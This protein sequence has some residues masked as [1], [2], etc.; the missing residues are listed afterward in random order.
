MLGKRFKR[1][2]AVVAGLL[3][4]YAAAGFWGVPWLVQRQ[5]PALEQA[6]RAWRA[7]AGEVRFNPF[8]LRLQARDLRLADVKGAPLLA[9]DGLEVELQWRSLW[10]RAWSFAQ[11][12]ISAPD[13]RLAIAPDGRFNL[14]QLLD[15][16]DALD[17][18]P[19]KPEQD[20]QPLPRLVVERLALTQGRLALDDRRAGYSN[21]FTPV[22][23]ELR[24]FST[25]PDSNDAYTLS[26]ETPRGGK[27][28]WKGQ[29]SLV[30]IRGNGEL[31]LEGVVLPDPAV[32]LKPYTRAGIA[33]GRLS[34]TLPYRFAYGDGRLDASLNGARLGVQ[35]LA[36][37]HQGSSEPFAT[38][39]HLD[40]GGV[41]AD[42]ARREVAV[43]EVKLS[44]GRLQARRD[45]QGVLDLATLMV[46]QGA[47]AEPATPATP[48]KA[49]ASAS[50]K[51]PEAA[52][53]APRPQ[54]QPASRAPQAFS[55]APAW[56]LAVKQVLL[57][58]LALGLVD[59]TVSPALKLSTGKLHLQLQLAAE[60]RGGQLQVMVS[61]AALALADMALASGGAT[62]VKLARLGFDGGALDLAAR[63]ASVGRVYLEGGQLQLVRDAKGRLNV[64]ELLPKAAASAPAPADAPWAAT[65]GTVALSQF[66]AE[67]HDQASGIRVHLQDMGLTLTS[68]STE[69]AKPVS[70]KAGLRVREGGQLSA[71][72]TLVPKDATLRAD[73]RVQALA[74]A[75]LQPLLAKHVRLHIAGGVV[76]AQGKLSTG[77]GTAKS[78]ALRYVGG[79]EVTRLVL[80]E[81]DGDLFAAWKRVGTDKLVASLSPNLLEMAELQVEE[82]NAKLI[83]EDDRSFNA[84]RLLVRAP[85]AAAPRQ[86]ASAA[87][88]APAAAAP[89][90]A[91]PASAAV[92]LHGAPA[93]ATAQDA[94]PDPFPVL[95]R[96]VRLRNAKLDFAD[97][98]LR[99]QFGAKIYELSGVINGLASDQRVRSQVELD[100]RV[101]EFG[102]ARVR[103]ELNP[104]APRDNTNLAVTFRNVDMVSATP[105]A[106]KFAGYKIAQ[107]KISL[108]L[109]YKVRNSQLEGDNKIVIDQLTLGERVDSPDALKLPL[110][111]AIAILKDSDGRIDLGLPVSGDMNNPQFSYGAIIWK[112]IGNVLTKIVTSPFR[113]LGALL[114]IS[115]EKLEAVDFDA[116]SASL[117]PPEREKLKQVA[118]LLAK[119]AQLKLAVP[120]AYSEAA[121]S[122]A[123]KTLALRN[124]VA[125][126]AGMKL[127]PGEAPGPLDSAD[128]AVRVALRD[129]YAKRFGAAE[130]DRQKQAAQA[131]DSNR[132]GAPATGASGAGGVGGEA[133]AAQK[134]PL[135]QRLG[136]LVQGEPQV[137]D[138]T[139]FYH[140]LQARL[141]QSQPLAGD[142]LARLGAQRAANIQ[143][144]LQEAGV[145]PARVALGAPEAV[146]GAATGKMVPVKLG[147]GAK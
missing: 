55:P 116:G 4:V 31:A 25:L 145:E 26:A 136:K 123:L 91:A 7:T 20:R 115:G 8:T 125:A 96:R 92:P 9:V 73:V 109:Q 113:A 42:L 69:L 60:Q 138:A 119:R 36:L 23:F 75:P 97:L 107:G 77:A 84:A 56:K 13:V 58:Q 50:A 43:G 30:P 46:A 47:P 68:A 86:A 38:L 2:V 64:L 51:T 143:A 61:D 94:G 29:L 81:D 48:A 6:T 40:V 70:F 140:G 54:A 15:A 85:G 127:A 59:E 5:L 12:S 121:D 110:E 27:L 98:S 105:Y 45:A 3:A 67:V 132:A 126:L 83:I 16:L 80:N 65:V 89:A 102:L 72:G 108:D 134:L 32:Y 78:A 114:G 1:A 130:L 88:S 11:I 99:P 131:A 66:A 95:I 147:L 90:S 37:V 76:S 139:A 18:G 53:V 57:D 19:P 93:A 117:L 122:A 87:A 33:S 39:A 49:A 100:G 142:A 118:T 44:E 79:L 128:K 106:M 133:T 141:E 24:H 17:K 82:P 103:G 28:R 10:R 146:G 120:G 135:W 74:L 34:A 124:E 137:A 22:A 35:D 62:P 71:Q 112:A 144:A 52:N 21:V 101:D 14:A 104:F 111:L 129:L 63:R 41:D